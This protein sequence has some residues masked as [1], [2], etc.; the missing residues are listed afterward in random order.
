MCGCL[1]VCVCVAVCVCM[2][3]VHSRVP[4]DH[5]IL[6]IISHTM[7]SYIED[8]LNQCG[9][10]KHYHQFAAAWIH[11][12]WRTLQF[13]HLLCNCQGITLRFSKANLT[14]IQS[15]SN[16]KHFHPCSWAISI[17]GIERFPEREIAATISELI[18]F[19]EKSHPISISLQETHS[20][21]KR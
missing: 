2:Y 8:L 16:Y 5:H 20:I 9:Q 21:S 6:N 10:N 15:H 3:G 13:C 1:C 14:R 11:L 7:H 4:K 17:A 12:L 18:W 19:I